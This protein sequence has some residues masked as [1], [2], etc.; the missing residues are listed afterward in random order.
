MLFSIFS[1]FNSRP[2][3]IKWMNFLKCWMSCSNAG[4]SDWPRILTPL[5]WGLSRETHNDQAPKFFFKLWN[6]KK[7]CLYLQRVWRSD[8]FF[9]ISVSG[10]LITEKNEKIQQVLKNEND[11]QELRSKMMFKFWRSKMKFNIFAKD[12]MND[13]LELLKLMENNDF[14]SLNVKHCT[15]NDNV[16]ELNSAIKA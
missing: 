16:I 13:V 1:N 7:M 14:L 8:R 12:V 9:L 10:L 11:V 4:R 3:Q 6:Y 15:N 5:G 2:F